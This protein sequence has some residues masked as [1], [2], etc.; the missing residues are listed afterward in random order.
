MGDEI[1]PWLCWEFLGPGIGGLGAV[2]FAGWMMAGLVCM[3]HQDEG[4]RLGFV[5]AMPDI[6]THK[7]QYV[8]QGHVEESNGLPPRDVAG[9]FPDNLQV[10][11]R[12]E[13]SRLC[14]APTSPLKLIDFSRSNICGC[15]YLSAFGGSHVALVACFGRQLS[16]SLQ[17]DL[18]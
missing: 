18:F 1:A 5:P 13:G 9:S 10:V 2:S 3:S 16:H 12:S 11:D 7:Q 6:P 15:C 8:I 4:C 17:L 14:T